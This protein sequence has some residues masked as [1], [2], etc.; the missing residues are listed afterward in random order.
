MD[1]ILIEE[2]K[3]VSSK[4]AA[5]ITGYAK[6]YIGQ[7]CREG[8][9]PAR[10]VGRSWYVL[11][12]AIQDH[13]FGEQEHSPKESHA[14][15]TVFGSNWDT[16]R[17]ESSEVEHIPSINKIETKVHVSSAEHEHKHV[18][19]AT[20]VREESQEKKIIALVEEKNH[21]D[22]VP[23]HNLS[24]E[25]DETR[26]SIEVPEARSHATRVD[27]EIKSDLGTVE[28]N[29]GYG[30]F[31]NIASISVAA[32]LGTAAFINSGALDFYVEN[33]KILQ[34]LSGASVFDKQPK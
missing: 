20:E 34:S 1:E 6:D 26:I 4:R 33:S 19:T 23:I 5:K 13:R 17:Y 27:S 12:S 28:K 24:A 3:Y 30:L 18:H 7:L 15:P 10:L 29:H 22:S 14:G 9:V 25:E 2:K 8:R 21:V 16:P 32:I 11:E 31:L